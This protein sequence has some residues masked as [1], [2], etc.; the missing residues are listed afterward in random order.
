VTLV[1]AML[2]LFLFAYLEVLQR[3]TKTED[4][5]AEP[6]QTEEKVLTPKE[7]VVEC[8]YSEVCSLLA[9]VAYYE[10]RSESDDGAMAPMFVAINRVKGNLTA[11]NLRKVVYK[12]WQFSYTHDGSLDRGVKE[13]QQYKRML[14]LAHSVWYGEVEDPTMGS[15]H[16]HTQTVKPVWRHKL[17]QTVVLGRHIFYKEQK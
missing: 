10:A 7:K 5:I 12:P 4:F 13:P 16:Y 8:S 3:A 2:C 15:T 9:E 11:R 17:N 6:V 1:I 14:V